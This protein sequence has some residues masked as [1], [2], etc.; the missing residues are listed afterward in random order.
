[1]M[2]ARVLSATVL[3]SLEWALSATPSFA[4][5]KPVDIGSRLELFVDD[6][7]VEACK[8]G[9]RRET[10]RPQ[11]KEVVFTTDRPWEGN[12]SGYF[13][14]FRDGEGYRM[15]Y[16]GWHWDAKAKKAAHGAVACVA[17]SRD[18]IRWVRPELGLYEFGGSRRNNVVWHGTEAQSFVPFKDA[19]PACAPDAKY[20]AFGLKKTRASGHRKLHAFKS[21]DGIR[22][23]RIG[24]VLTKGVTKRAFDSQNLAF[25]DPERG[26]YRAYFRDWRGQT[27]IIKTALSK[28]FSNWSKGVP[29]RYGDAPEEQLY[30]NAVQPYA[31]APHILIGFPVRYLPGEGH[32]VEPLF[33]A[34]RDGALFERRPEAVIPKNA[35]R[36]RTGNRSNYMAWGVLRLPGAKRELSVYAT[37]GYFKGPDSRLRRFIYRVDGFVALEAPAAGGELVT[38]ALRFAG[39]KLVVNFRTRTG[40]SV[41]VGLTDAAGQPVK[42]RGLE[43]C[44][45]LRGDAIGQT[46][47]WRDGADLRDL[48]G[49]AV[50]VRFALKSAQV[51][52]YRFVP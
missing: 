16:R 52:S 26:A 43:A 40:G 18:G 41:R 20:K 28:D 12:I 7:L 39:G 4:S 11:P 6:A 1:M 33:M 35:P 13:N 44:E 30:T 21:A 27:R 5:E 15:Y 42:G 48:A 34:G 14:V 45:P 31:R 50:R 49:K 19:N 51:F 9:A 17:H 10:Q 8:G 22:W 46:V 24:P 25:W 38:K 29:L 2:H 36:E 47:R 37:E 32:R 23:K 3:V